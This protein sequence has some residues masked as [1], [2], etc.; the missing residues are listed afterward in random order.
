RR[1]QE[2]EAENEQRAKEL[3]EARQLQLS[4][5]PKSVPQLPHV[6]IAAVMKTATE[7]GGDYYD[8]HV[9][10]DGALTIAIGDATGHGLKAG[11]VVAATKGL[12]NHLAGQS[13]LVATLDQA[14]RAL[15]RMN[16]RSLFMALTLVK[17]NG[18]HLQCG[19]AGMPPILIYRAATQTVE[20]IPLRGA[21]LGGL[22]SYDYRQ[23]ELTLAV[24]DT[25]LLLSDGLPERFNAAGEMFGYEV[26]K[27]LLL[28]HASADPQILL[29]RL[30][31]AGDEWAAGKLA[32]DDMTF[33]ALRRKATGSS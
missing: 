21:P 13:D 27:E 24:N 3:E 18:D 19:V 5:L 32:D 30:L 29:E 28:A 17:L 12:F 2:I 4:M 26:I 7:V 11:T 8:F 33:V 10:A 14:S 6:E 16:L 31:Q 9:G 20:E 1:R 22:S 15:K 23:A 25:V